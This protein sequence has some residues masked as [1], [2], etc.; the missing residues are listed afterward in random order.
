MSAAYS[1]T[2]AA[3]EQYRPQ[4]GYCAADPFLPEKTSAGEFYCI[5]QEGLDDCPQGTYFTN[6]ETVDSCRGPDGKIDCRKLCEKLQIRP[7]ASWN[8][9][10]GTVEYRYPSEVTLYQTR[11]GETVTYSEGPT[12]NNI[13]LGEGGGWQYQM[14]HDRKVLDGKLERSG[15]TETCVNTRSHLPCF[16]QMEKDQMGNYPECNEII[17]TEH[18][19]QLQQLENGTA[20]QQGKAQDIRQRELEAK[21]HIETDEYRASKRVRE[22][23]RRQYAQKSESIAQR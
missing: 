17:K 3:A 4:S 6:K 5:H 8:T 14:S 22:L 12:T 16:K 10:S 7:Q 20:E 18:D 13:I 21:Q 1:N 2:Q 11:P 23:E 19:I 15:P 9:Q